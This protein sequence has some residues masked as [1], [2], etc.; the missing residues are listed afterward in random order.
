M[1][2]GALSGTVKMLATDELDRTNISTR[3]TPPTLVM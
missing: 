3:P 2:S 1:Y